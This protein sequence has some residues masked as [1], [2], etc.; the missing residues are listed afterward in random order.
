MRARL[1]VETLLLEMLC[2]QVVLAIS[3]DQG[4]SAGVNLVASIKA[5]SYFSSNGQLLLVADDDTSGIQVGT[6]DVAG[7]GSPGA[8]IILVAQGNR[9][10]LRTTLLRAVIA[11]SLAQA[12]LASGKAD[13]QA[14]QKIQQAV[15]V[16][17]RG[18]FQ[19]SSAA[20]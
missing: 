8:D 11:A 19:D 6:E 12:A 15:T 9:T 20:M 16:F 17:P 1:L 5:T 18:Q 4:W 2:V 13:Q 7:T 3:V 14:A 10:L